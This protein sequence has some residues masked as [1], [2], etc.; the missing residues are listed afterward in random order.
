MYEYAFRFD[1]TK[2][3]EKKL[4]ILLWNFKIQTSTKSWWHTVIFGYA[5]KVWDIDLVVSVHIYCGQVRIP[6][7]AGL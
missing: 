7:E 4:I 3:K 6:F 2:V 5:S 1:D